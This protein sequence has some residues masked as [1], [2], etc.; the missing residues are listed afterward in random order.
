M[1]EAENRLKIMHFASYALGA[2][3]LM[4]YLPL[5]GDAAK[6]RSTIPC[7]ITSQN[8]AQDLD[9]LVTDSDLQPELGL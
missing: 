8:K 2:A 1:T 5:S 7:M 3:V 9:K 6:H 4:Y